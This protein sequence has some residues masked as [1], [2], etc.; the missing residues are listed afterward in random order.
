MRGPNF[1][2][3]DAPFDERWIPE[4][5]SGCFLWLS[6]L[7]NS[8]T[9]RYGRLQW[10]G[11]VRLAH[12]VAW[13]LVHGGELARGTIIRHACDTPACVNP[14][15]LV[16]GTQAENLDDCRRKLRDRPPRKLTID[17]AR[18][19]DRLVA[20]GLLMREVA[21]RFGVSTQAVKDL[22]ARRTF[23]RFLPPRIS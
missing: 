4:P 7:T 18:E 8:A 6:S 19:A 17:Q 12:R 20:D 2:R 15:H 10:K 9:H 3:R 16:A 13:E 5:N 1:V 22:R 14:T 21:E 11:R 23:A